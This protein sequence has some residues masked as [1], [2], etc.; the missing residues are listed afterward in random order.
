MQYSEFEKLILDDIVAQYPEY[1]PNLARQLASARVGKRTIYAH[2]FYTEYEIE[3][4][5]ARIEGATTPTLGK[6]QWKLND[7]RYGSD[8]ILWLREGYVA[9][10][11]GFSYGEPWPEEITFAEVVE[12]TETG[13]PSDFFVPGTPA[14][15][16]KEL[17]DCAKAILASE[18]NPAKAPAHSQAVVCQ[19]KSGKI[20]CVTND[21]GESPTIPP[22]NTEKK[23]IEAIKKAGNEPIVRLLCEWYN[24]GV[25]LPSY[26]FRKTLFDLHPMN[27]F[28]EILLQGR[29]GF[30]TKLLSETLY[31]ADAAAGEEKSS[32]TA[33]KGQKET[34]ELRSGVLPTVPLPHD[35]PIKEIKIEG[36]RL[37]LI[38]E[39]GIERYDSVRFYRPGARS[40][41]MTFE[42][43]DGFFAYRSDKAEE[44][45]EKIPEEEFLKLPEDRLEYLGHFVGHG[46]IVVKL[47]SVRGGYAV[48][49]VYAERVELSWIDA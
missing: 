29:D 48:A 32:S 43:Y 16:F 24:D 45:Y 2:G 34:Y 22:E 8:Y 21:Y 33:G 38:F 25:D 11:E 30:H 28:A 46:E 10:L 5:D 41:V 6:R 36:N 3:D 9:G 15:A 49:D 40:L 1:A 39:D 27:G 37:I 42:L 4:R 18:A 19:T 23:L 35:C 14:A 7:L 44:K 31:S 47:W 12:E 20:H 17:Y 13:H 26:N